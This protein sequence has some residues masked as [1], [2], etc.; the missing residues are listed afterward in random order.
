[1]W[2]LAFHTHWACLYLGRGSWACS[3]N[4]DLRSLFQIMDII[5]IQWV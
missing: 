3:M 1:M 2:N 5:I 4:S